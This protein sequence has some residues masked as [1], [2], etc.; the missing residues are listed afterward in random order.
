M[1]K[2]PFSERK[3]G[4]RTF[5]REFRKST[6]SDELI[7]HRDREDRVVEVLKGDNWYLQLDNELPVLL[8]QGKK[9]KIPK[10]KYHRLIKGDD[11]LLIR[12]IKN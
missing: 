6:N 8:E 9:Y 3:V 5:L 7:W 11:N 4:D 2:F 12:L 10:M 1:R